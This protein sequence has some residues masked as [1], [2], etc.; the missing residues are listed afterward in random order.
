[1]SSWKPLPTARCLRMVTAEFG[2]DRPATRDEEE[3]R[4]EIE[5]IVGRE[6]RQ[7]LAVERQPPVR[8]KARVAL[9]EAER[10][11]GRRDDVAVRLADDER[12]ALEGADGLLRH[13]EIL[14]VGRKG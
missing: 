8:E 14:F 11:V 9:E 2:V 5:E 7:R 10:L 3:L 4:L 12:A 1:M 13:P 6:R